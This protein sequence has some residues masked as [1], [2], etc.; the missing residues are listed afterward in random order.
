MRSTFAPLRQRAGTTVGPQQTQANLELS[1]DACQAPR[2]PTV[3][4]SPRA[5][6]RSA[7]TRAVR[8]GPLVRSEVDLLDAKAADI[9]V[10]R[11]RQ[12]LVLLQRAFDAGIH[13][14]RGARAE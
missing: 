4:V 12:V 10:G 2:A 8:D 3:G 14:P 11:H 13:A 6:M 9:A 5:Q 7:Q 1:G